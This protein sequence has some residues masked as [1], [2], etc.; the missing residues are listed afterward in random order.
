MHN[1]LQGAVLELTD[2]Q[3]ATYLASAQ[4]NALAFTEEYDF[5]FMHD[6]QPAAILSIRGKGHARWIWRCHIDT[7][8]PNPD[9]WAFLQ[10]FLAEYDAAI[11]TMSAFA[12]P[13][14]PARRIEIIPPAIDPA[15]PKNLP[16]PRETARQVLEWL[17]VRTDRPLVTQISRF[18][19]WKD[20]LG[21]IAAYR[22]VREEVSDLQLVLAA[23]VCSTL[24]ALDEALGKPDFNYVLHTA[25]TA[26]E[27]KPYYLWH[28][29]ILP[30]IATLA[31]FE[32]G[33]GI[34]IN[35]FFPEDAAS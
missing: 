20:P 18:D 13:D 31:G 19:P 17:G 23:V 28:L 24:R 34:P 7:S 9:L 16:L 30:R 35:T 14:M 4:E 29:Q 33:S 22:K 10:P 3:K 25:P 21:V 32:L 27:E 2:G 8:E 1:G 12:P 15:S 11:F 5:V 26:D 6:A